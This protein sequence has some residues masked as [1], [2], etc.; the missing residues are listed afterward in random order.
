MM[1]TQKAMCQADI[2]SQE[3]R[4]Q[5]TSWTYCDEFEENGYL[6]IKN[7]WDPSAL[8]VPVPHQRGQIYYYGK[9][10]K[11]FRYVPE[12][13][14]VPGSLAVV[15]RPSY[16]SVHTD[17]RRKIEGVL[18]RKLYNTY[19]YDRF[20]WSGQQLTKHVDRDACEISVTLHIGSSC[21]EPWPIWLKCPDEY[22][23]DKKEIVKVGENRKVILGPGDGMLYK[24]CERPHW[25]EVLDGDPR[26]GF[27]NWYHQVFFHYVLQDGIRA[28]CAWDMG[29]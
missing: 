5:G 27:E 18:K 17:I 2:D 15:N 8:S 13:E 3:R 19:Y 9:G 11:D 26:P 20:Y 28:Q 10:S 4:C 16:R 25:R 24:G 29:R 7:L 22:T 21:S 14:Q 12:E 1:T 6:I 23:A